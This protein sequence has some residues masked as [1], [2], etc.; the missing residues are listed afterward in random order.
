MGPKA[1]PAP[2][3]ALQQASMA[4]PPKR[5]PLVCH[6]TTVHARHDTRVFQK[7]CKSL[8]QAGF[9]VV[10][11]VADGKGDAIEAGVE[12]IDL[13]R[14]SGRAQRATRFAGACFRKA[15]ALAAEVYQIHDPELLWVGALLKRAGKRVIFDSH[16][17]IH[18]SI[19]NKGYIP[20]RLRKAVSRGYV[21]IE[22][23]LVRNLDA[24]FIPQDLILGDYYRPR[25][26]RV[27]IVRNFVSL[28]DRPSSRSLKAFC[29]DEP[30]RLIYAGGLSQSRGLWHMLDV[31]LELG[32]KARL[33]LAGKFAVAQEFERAKR[34]P[35]WRFVDYLGLLDR[36]TLAT[37]YEKAHIGLILFES[38][39]QYEYVENPLKLYEYLLFG[40]PTITPDFSIWRSFE[41]KHGVT[42]CVAST[43]A[44]A[45]AKQ[46]EQWCADAQRYQ[47]LS[48]KARETVEENYSWEAES[49]RFL[50]VYNEL[51]GRPEPISSG[52]RSAEAAA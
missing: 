21:A 13:G 25:T 48:T 15:V 34:H 43:D 29:Q 42:K 40:L 8:A 38:T 52:K 51:C 39:G 31:A 33:T 11:V 46:I 23:R 28:S 9:R 19:L 10:L 32:N 3:V 4:Q 27:E 17:I 1:L 50:T 7:H 12:V 37:H 45:V 14:P 47:A 49:E 41:R 44:K 22:S 18:M 26:K 24:V 36:Q 20:R 30:I 35:G 16:E 5:R 2:R 6:L